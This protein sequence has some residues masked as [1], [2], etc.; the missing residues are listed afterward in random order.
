[1]S[2]QFRLKPESHPDRFTVLPESLLRRPDFPAILQEACERQWG[3]SFADIFIEDPDG[4]CDY[5]IGMEEIEVVDEHGNVLPDI[6]DESM[7]IAIPRELVSILDE[8]LT[9][10][11]CAAMQLSDKGEDVDETIA[12]ISGAIDLLNRAVKEGPE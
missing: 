8:A 9:C 1:M 5:V 4:A 10:G 2:Y 12:E 3:G 7:A 11:L 6:A